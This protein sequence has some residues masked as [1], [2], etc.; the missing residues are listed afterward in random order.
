M[1]DSDSIL[2]C[3]GPNYVPSANELDDSSSEDVYTMLRNRRRD[4]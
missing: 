3:D 2:D 4:R 1:A